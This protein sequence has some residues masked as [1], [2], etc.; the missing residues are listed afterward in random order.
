MGGT[1]Y[2]ALLAKCALKANA[3]TIYTWDLEH[4][5]RL[6]PEVARPGP[7]S[8]RIYPVP[9]SFT[10][11]KRS[12]FVITETELKLMAAAARIGLS[13]RPKKG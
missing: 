7:D 2:D 12:E 8:V 5:R 9:Y 4:F 6:G 3:T 13:N 10:F 1:I 11:R